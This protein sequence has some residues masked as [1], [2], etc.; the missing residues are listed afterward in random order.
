VGGELN[1]YFFVIDG[2]VWVM[3]FLFRHL[4]DFIDEFYSAPERIQF[5]LV[6]DFFGSNNLPMLGELLF[7]FFDLGC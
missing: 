1:G 2:D 4:S 3:V 6:A 7:K 5:E